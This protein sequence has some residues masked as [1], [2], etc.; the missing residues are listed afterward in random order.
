[1]APTLRVVAAQPGTLRVPDAERPW[2]HSHAEHGND[3]L[4]G[5]VERSDTRQADYQLLRGLL[6][7]AV[8]YRRLNPPYG[9]GYVVVPEFRVQ[10]A[11]VCR[12]LWHAI[13]GTDC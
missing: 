13:R 2:R 11:H 4:E 12:H 9:L 8:G 3:Q 7:I 5:W 10:S 6:G 1:M